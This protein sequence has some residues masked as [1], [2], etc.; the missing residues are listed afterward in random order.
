M[1]NRFIIFLSIVLFS[2]TSCL[3]EDPPFLSD[4]N[5]F[6]TDEGVK[7]AVNGIYSA[8][9]GFNYYSSDFI[10]L[11]DYHSGMFNS[12]RAQD[13]TG[14]AAL[15]TLPNGTFVENVWKA[16][17]QT[18]NR[19]NETIIGVQ[20][21]QENPSD[22]T[23][24]EVGQAYFLRAVIY[25]NLVRLFGEVPIR[26]EK[27]N[28]ETINAPKAALDSVYQLIISDLKMAEENLYEKGVQTI[29]RPAKQAANMLLAQVYMTMAGN[30]A[31]SEYWAMA[32]EEAM[33][34]YGQYQ[35]VADYTTLWEN[36]SRN[37]T[38]EAIFEIQ[39]NQAN[40]GNIIRLHTP[41]NAFVG[42]S[43][44]RVLVNPEVID[45]HMNQYPNDP[46]FEATMMYNYI[47][48]NSDG[49][50]NGEQKI[51]PLVSRRSKA[52]S[53]PF[54]GKYW[55][56]DP[57]TPTPYSDANFVIM[58][59]SELLLMLAEITNE[60]DGPGAAEQYVNE[61]V[62][63]ARNS[64]GGDGSVPANWSGFSQDEFRMRIMREYQYELL[65]EGGEWFR[66]RRRGLDYFKNEVVNIHNERIK[67]DGNEG[68]DVHYDDA[69]K[70][71]L[72]PIPL[73]EINTNLMIT[74]D[75]Q[76][77]GY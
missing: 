55:I 29:G 53:F 72:Q 75:D 28:I 16:S 52:N 22:V 20:N 43:W 24:N 33:K 21:F 5:L 8:I 65:G 6:T 45:Y 17:Y 40:S 37:N 3:K 61:V 44:G 51:Y 18:I 39:Y 67:L 4:E 66:N 35:L 10:Q 77:P 2:A 60:I 1:K 14:V 9:A 54:V 23:L 12:G 68:V 63:R 56:W 70:A 73:S 30:D 69:E 11:V 62:T 31:G 57:K 19:S 7:V 50:E 13:Q 58:R 41:S 36:G 46:R 34:V 27:L 64:T 47:K 74:V 71:M 26:T 15:N 32:K 42:Q 38:T 25:F 76:N 59:Y 49:T 48:Y